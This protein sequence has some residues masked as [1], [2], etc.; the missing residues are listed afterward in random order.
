[1]SVYYILYSLS[2][3]EGGPTAFPDDLGEGASVEKPLNFM[4]T[5]FRR[6]TTNPLNHTVRASGIEFE[7]KGPV[8]GEYPSDYGSPSSSFMLFIFLNYKVESC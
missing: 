1:M 8:S 7:W 4:A 3:C 2:A 5:V 6:N